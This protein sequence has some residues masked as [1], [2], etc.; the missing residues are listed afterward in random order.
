MALPGG[1]IRE[2][3]SLRMPGKHRTRSVHMD[4]YTHDGLFF[5]CLAEATSAALRKELA[6]TMP[7]RV[8]RYK[9]ELA[10]AMNR[11]FKSHL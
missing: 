3:P 1:I 7:A 8:Q 11:Y 9:E 6:K 10:D 5:S 4:T 2:E